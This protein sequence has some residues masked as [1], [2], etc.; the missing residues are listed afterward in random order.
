MTTTEIKG[1]EIGNAREA[2]GQLPLTVFLED[3]RAKRIDLVGGKGASLA[4]LN[5]IPGVKV[6]E[7]FVITTSL[8]NQLLE[9]NSEIREKVDK[10]DS[11]S[12][13]WLRA[14]LAGDSGEA[15]R[16]E[17][18]MSIGGKSLREQLIGIELSPGV[19]NEIIEAY[20]KLCETTGVENVDVAVR[21]SGKSEDGGSNS[22]AGQYETFLHQEGEKEV[23]NSV[24]KCLASQFTERVI[25][26]RNEARLAITDQVL[27]DYPEDIEKA[28]AES[29]KFSHRE[30]GLAVVVQRMVNAHSAGVG[31][32][33]DSISGAKV[34]RIDVNYGLGES[35]V[36]G[37]VT[38]DAYFVDPITG[39]I[40]GRTLG[41]KTVRTVYIEGGTENVAVPEEERKR[42]VLP[43]E[44]IKQI[45]RAITA[46]S[47]HYEKPMDTEFALGADGEVYFTQARPETVASNK[48][49][50][51]VRMKE[52]VVSEEAA[53]AAEEIFK[54]G[55]SG[56]PGAAAGIKL[57]AGTVDEANILLK[58]DRYKGKEVILVTDRTDPDWVLIMKKVKGIITRVGGPNCH[59]AIVSRELGIPCLV[60]V[61]DK[62]EALKDSE[63]QEITLDVRGLKVYKGKLPLKEVGVDIDVREI[64]NNPTETIVGVNM[65]MPEEAR[66]L[67]A[68]AELG[69]KFK[70]SLLRI[71]FLLQDIGVHVNALV[72]FDERKIDPN[73]DLYKGIA[74]KIAGYG[75]GREYYI[76]KLSEGIASIAS[77]FPN[78]DIVLRT[79]DF[80]TNEYRSLIGGERY[81]VIEANPMMGERG[82]V[83]SLFPK[84]RA[85]FKWELEAIKKARDMG[86]KS[87][88]IM[89]PVVRDPKELTGGPELVAIRFKGAYEIMEEVGMRR[90]KDGLKVGIMVEDPANVVRINDFIDAGLDFISFGTNDLTQFTL[91][92]DRDNGVLAKIPWYGE[93]N[94]AVVS[95]VRRV[96]QICKSRG[97]ETGICGNAPS[98]SPE[99]V[100]MLVEEGIDSIGVTPDRLLPTYELVRQE[101]RKRKIKGGTIFISA[102]GSVGG[103]GS[104]P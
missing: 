3:P 19:K 57:I 47:E 22:S 52:Y 36:S 84:N 7:A 100:R 45:A 85:A 93:T 94:P 62:I 80:K 48:D 46:I 38:P 98:N 12:V 49:Q 96:I 82:L 101:E 16:L 34:A 44:K 4:E 61:G 53:G 54:G 25:V 87:V 27:K 56:C 102:S 1:F 11:L 15:E 89:F 70:I 21:S 2:I 32:S 6:P 99:F 42:F 20:G 68:L 69:E 18:Q 104:R 10:L 58:S 60:G 67:H 79:T 14:K 55:V 95:Q 72:D 31:F 24:K 90:G 37:S 83:R 13:S 29:K 97:V 74:D 91:A 41:A 51:V 35:V 59:A 77:T 30:A 43:D 50:M 81:E 65:A 88:K 5:T 73:S 103:N 33:I 92:V 8:C 86:Y 64:L 39:E 66:K 40:V 9:Q 71:E 75:S 76:G 23:L 26:Y 63:V 28:L 17:K 78:S